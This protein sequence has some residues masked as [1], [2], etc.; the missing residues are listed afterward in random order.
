MIIQIQFFK[1]SLDAFKKINTHNNKNKF[2]TY[3]KIKNY[4]TMIV[5]ITTTVS[6]FI[7]HQNSFHM[8]FFLF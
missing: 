8:I 6:Y 3:A 5:K 7:S 2:A 4:Y 1:P